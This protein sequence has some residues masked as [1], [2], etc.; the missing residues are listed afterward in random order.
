MR[1]LNVCFFVDG[2]TAE[3]A[4]W[5]ALRLATVH[6]AVYAHSSTCV[7]HPEF[8]AALRDAHTLDHVVIDSTCTPCDISPVADALSRVPVIHRLDVHALGSWQPAFSRLLACRNVAASTVA[9]DCQIETCLD[10]LCDAL[11]A[12]PSL[13][14]VLCES[15][16]S[17]GEYAIACLRLALPSGVELI[18]DDEIESPRP[19]NALSV[20]FFLEEPL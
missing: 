4:G 13:T 10:A 19:G 6:F 7:L 5:L 15:P 17:I 3:M 8:T 16:S 20:D 18:L 14:R 11:R 9:L 2:L 12:S 1:G